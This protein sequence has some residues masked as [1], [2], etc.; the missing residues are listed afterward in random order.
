MSWGGETTL[1]SS[2]T[3]LVGGVSA[4]ETIQNGE[5]G[6]VW[7]EGA[8]SPYTV[9][10]ALITPTPETM[11]TTHAEGIWSG[12]ERYI[13]HANGHYWAVF[14]DGTEAVLFSSADASS[15]TSQGTVNVLAGEVEKPSDVSARFSGTTII[16]AYGDAES[17]SPWNQLY[18]RHGT[19]NAGGTVTWWPAASD[20]LVIQ[21]ADHEL[22]THAAFDSNGL[23]WIGG[24]GLSQEHFNV[25]RGSAAQSPTWTD[26]STTDYVGTV[27][28]GPHS[29]VLFPIA[30]PSDMYGL[31]SSN[32][33]STNRHIIGTGWDDSAGSWGSWQE[34]VATDLYD[35]YNA[36]N[37]C[38]QKWSAAKTSVGEIHLAYIDDAGVIKHRKGT[39][40]LA[41]VWSTVDADVTGL[42]SHRRLTLTANGNNLVLIY[43]KNDDKLYYREW[44]G[45]SWS[46]ELT[47]KSSS[48]PLVG[49]VSAYE[50]V[51]NGEI[52]VIWADGAAS[53]YTVQFAL[54][55]PTP[56]TMTMTHTDGIWSGTERYIHHANGH[57]WAVFY[58]GT[59]AVLFSSPDASTWTSQG[60]VNVL[61]GEVEKPADV[62][63]RFSGTTVIVAYG[64]D[65]TPSPYNQLYYRHGTLNAGG[66]VT[67]WPA[68]SDELIV[69]AGDHETNTHAAFD[70]AGLPWIG[71]SGDDD[72]N[73]FVHRGSAAQ[74]PTWTDRSTTDYGGTTQGGPHSTVLFPIADPG[75]M[76]GLTNAN[77]GSS[78]RDIIGTGWDDS[79]GSWGSWQE[80]VAT[81]LSN[82]A[83]NA[84]D[85]MR[86]WSAVK[87]SLGEIHLV[88]IDDAGV[89]KHRKGTNALAPVWSTVDSDVTGLTSHERLT[90]AANDNSLVLV[91]DKNDEKLYYREWDGASWSGE[92]TLKSSSTPLVGGVSAYES[93]QNGEI[94]VVWA[95]GAASPYDVIFALISPAASAAVTGTITPSSDEA[96]IVSGG[97][98]VIITLMGDTWVAAGATFDAER[99]AII[100]GLDS[101][102][103]EG[104]GWDAVVK[105]GLGVTDVV[106]TSATVVTVTLPAFG[107]YDI[108]ATETI[109]VTV[110]AS[111][112]SGAG[113]IAATP[114]FDV[115]PVGPTSEGFNDPTADATRSGTPATTPA[116]AYTAN[117]TYADI[118]DLTEHDYFTYGFCIPSGATIQGV[119][120][121]TEWHTTK[122]T[123]TGYLTL[124]L[125]S[126]VGTLFGSTK[127]TPT[128]DGTTDIVHTLG[129]SV[130]GWGAALTEPIIN[131]TDFG[132]SLLY[133]KTAGGGGNHAFVDNVDIKVHFS[134]G[135][136]GCGSGTAAL[137][138]TITPSTTESEIVSGGK[139]LAITLT[140]DTWVA[141]GPT[142]DAERQA[143]IN[144]LDSAQGEANGWD[145]VVKTGLAVTDVART[146]STVVTVTLPAFGS[147]DISA[148][149]TISATVPASALVGT[150]AILATPTF[151]ITFET[152]VAAVTGTI[153]PS[154][155]EAD[156]V[157]GGKTVLLTLTGDTWVAAGPTFDAE[158]QNIIDGLD[159]A[160]AETNGWDAEVKAGLAVTD[161]VRTSATLVTVTLPAFANYDVGSNETITATVPASAL[162]GTSPLVATPT[163]EVIAYSL[164]GQQEFVDDG[165]FTVP[166]GVTDITIKAWGGGGGSGSKAIASG[167]DGAAGGYVQHDVSGLTG[168]DTFTIAIGRAGEGGNTCGTHAGGAGGYAGG[169]GALSGPGNDGAGSGSGGLGGDGYSTFDGGDGKWGSGGGGGGASVVTN[170]QTTTEI[171]IAGGGGGG[172]TAWSAAWGGNGGPGCAQVGGDSGGD[173][174]GGGGGGACLGQTTQSGSAQTPANAAE[175][176]GHAEGGEGS[177]TT[178]AQKK[179][180]DGKVVI[181]WGS[182]AT[183][184]LKGTLVPSATRGEIA[185][186]GETLVITLNGDTWDGA[187]GADNAQTTALISGIDSNVAEA[188]GWDAVVKADLTFDDVVRTSDTVVT[189]TL[190]LEPTY[191]IT[192]NE[193]ITVT[194]PATAL[195]GGSS[196]I[197]TPTFTINPG[198]ASTESR[199]AAAS[200]DAEE[201]LS[202]NAVDLSGA[203]LQLIDSGGAQQVGMRF[204]NLLIPPGSTVTNAYLEFTTDAVQSGSTNL[205]FRAE[206]AD[207]PPTFG[208]PNSDISVRTLTTASVAWNSVP[209][210]NTLD[211]T[212]QT[213]DLSSVI[214]EIVDLGG[215]TA[216]NAMALHA[217]GSGARTA[218]AYDG[219]PAE[220]PLLHI[221]FLPGPPPPPTSSLDIRV[222]A[223]TDDAEEMLG[224]GAVDL[225]SNDLQL[226]DDS[227]AQEVGMRFLN[228]TVPPGSTI[229]NAYLEFTADVANLGTTDLTVHG[230]AADDPATFAGGVADLSGRL[231]TDASVDWSGVAAWDTPDQAYQSADLSP[232]VQELID[233]GGWTSGNAVALLVSGSGRRTGIAYDQDSAKA[234]LLHLEYQLPAALPPTSVERRISASDDDAEERISDGATSVTSGDLE[235]IEEA[236]GDQEVGMRF[237]NLTI[238]KGAAITNAYIE[239]TTQQVYSG[240]TDLTFHAQA[241]DD[242]TTFTTTNSDITN[243][244]KSAASV[245][246]NSVPAW[247]TIGE[248]HRTPDLSAIIQETVDRSGWASGN[249]LAVIVTGTGKREA[250]AYDTNPLAAPLLHIEY[251]PDCNDGNICTVDTWDYATQ[252]CSN[253]GPAAN[254]FACSDSLYCTTGNLCAAGVCGA[255]VDCSFLDNQCAVGTCDEATDACVAQYSTSWFDQ[256]WQY[257]KAITIDS[258]KV[259][260]DLD[261]FPVLVSFTDTDLAAGARD[262]GFDLAFTDSDGVTQLDHEIEKYASGTGEL[263]AWVRVRLSSTTDKQIYLYYG[264]PAAADQQTVAGVWTSNYAAVWHLKEEQSGTGNNGL[265]QDS[266]SNNRDADDEVSA[267]GQ[268]GKIGAGQQVD[269]TDDRVEIPSSATTG[270][271]QFAFSVWV[272]T[273]E[274]GTNGSYWL[275]PSVFGQ[276]TSGQST[277]DAGITTNNGYIGFW[278]G[279]TPVSDASYLSST[280]QVNDDA[281]HHI[282]LSND[283]ANAS[284]YVD[285][286]FQSSVATGLSLNS[287]AFWAGAKGGPESPGDH[288]NGTLDE[289]RVLSSPLS[290]DWI[291][292]EYNNQSSPG[293][294]YSL[295]AEQ[296]RITTCQDCDDGNVCTV[297]S[298]NSGSG[299]CDNDAG[300]ADGLSCSDGLF[301]TTGDICSSGACGTATD[302]SYLDNQCIL[303]VCD[304]GTDACIG[305]GNGGWYDANWTVRKVVTVD[306]AQ[307][308]ADLSDF[309]VLVSVTDAELAAGARADGF[310]F[311]FTDTDEITKLDHEIEKYDSGTG[312]L[313]AWV[314]VPNLTSAVDKVLYLYYGNAS[315]TNQQNPAGV[316]DSNY[317]SVHHLAETP[318]G[319]GSGSVSRVGSWTTSQASSFTYNVGAGSDR[320][321]LVATGY[322]ESS[323]NDTDVTGVTWGGQALTPISEATVFSSNTYARV[324]LWYLDESGV[325]AA[326]GSS[327]AVTYGNGG[328]DRPWH[329]VTTYQDVDQTTPIADSDLNS[330]TSVDPIEATVNVSNG[331]MAVASAFCGDNSTYTWGNGW[332]EGADEQ[333]GSETIS[334]AEHPASG[335]GTDTASAD[336]DG[337]MNRQVIVAAV[338]N[339]A[340]GG[341]T[342]LDS[343]AN[344]N[345]GQATGS[346]D[347]ADQVAGQIAGSL[348]FDASDDYVAVPHAPSFLVDDGS[349]SFWFK[350]G[351]VGTAQGLWCKDSANN[352]TGGHLCIYLMADSTLSARI[353]DTATGYTVASS[354]VSAGTWY[355]VTFSFGGAGMKLH[356]NAGAPATD[357]YTGG[358]GTSSGGAGNFEPAAFGAANDLSDDLIGT[359]IG[360]PFG[361]QL[362]EVRFSTLA[363]PDAWIQTE[364]SNQSAPGAFLSLSAEESFGGVCG[365]C[366]DSN[367]CTID[368]WDSGTETCTN[369]AGAANGLACADNLFCTTGNLCAA[370]VCGA[371][372]DCSFLDGECSIGACDEPSDS[373]VPQLQGVCD[374]DDGNSCTTDSFDSATFTCLHNPA[375]NN[376]LA[377]DDG[378]Y[379]TS[380]ETCE[381]GFCGNGSV[382]DCTSEDDPAQCLIGVCDEATDACVGRVSGNNWADTDWT[383]R[384]TITVDSSKVL[385]DQTNFPVLI[386]RTDAELAA[387]A[388]ADGFDIFFTDDDAQTKL[389]HEIEKYV[390]GTGELVA[391]VRVPTLTG[392]SDKTLYMYYGNAADQQN[393]TGVWDA[394]FVGVY[395]LKEPLTA[396]SGSYSRRVGASYDDAEEND[397]GVIDL[398]SSDLELIEEGS[399]QEVGMR[400]SSMGIPVGATI[401][402]AYIE[403]TVD[404]V[405]TGTPSDLNFYAQ[406]AD[407]AG[408]FSSTTNDIS[409]RQKTATGVAWNSVPGWPTVAATHQTPDLS[410]IIQEVVDRPG[411]ASGNAI[412]VIVTGVGTRTAES[413]NGAVA[414]APLLV[415]DY[416]V[417]VEDSTSNTNHGTTLG[418][419]GSGNQVAGKI[420]WLGHPVQ[421]HRQRHP[422]RPRDR[423]LRQRYRYPRGLGAGPEPDERHR[424][425][426]LPA[427]RRSR[428]ARPVQPARRLELGL[429]RRLAPERRSLGHG[430]S[431]AG[432]HVEQQRRQLQ[433]NHDER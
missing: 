369:D 107:S 248:T 417:Y 8:A 309:A 258:A 154:A 252:S 356:V 214:Q 213:P 415:V 370:G 263:V 67:W 196:V 51:Q 33:F 392:S 272:K 151:A 80:V 66:T 147:F 259:T 69:Q 36:S 355:H 41:P 226:V 195:V 388:R 300:A 398:T 333:G 129:S 167:G 432:Q 111:A 85:C 281:W 239:F 57:Y 397:S 408:T 34:V 260:A 245:T 172:G 165:V 203:A 20:H 37:K 124:Q 173:G 209:S 334:T 184:G 279:V 230:Q 318:S 140:G 305:Q 311:V 291:Q 299:S 361:G 278:S 233:R 35:C 254:G 7:A 271:S 306:S 193:T 43:D 412:V 10:F 75:D 53:P 303:G 220:A 205:T 178:C 236:S 391:W 297:D 282:L 335:G 421:G 256:D 409:S 360:F 54:I 216:G 24:S 108:A 31:T 223:S 325:Q 394:N 296:D 348:D 371:A 46:A 162:V 197:A 225:A 127:V 357:A 288:H 262:D 105:A 269:R 188:A 353:Q 413:Y 294:F 331:A 176:T 382:I 131:D 132:V 4:Y 77:A 95:E 350:A 38:H 135:S 323:T 319:G 231:K 389:D 267:T 420:D 102:Q 145:A 49:G 79:A 148:N 74:S 198:T 153:T 280:L 429:Q 403:F 354:A 44:D 287:T 372:T 185:S 249:A 367:S 427:L 285:G 302:C 424:Q 332:S 268:T 345:D 364:Y 393:V 289:L 228:V 329:A 103:A 234:P 14:Y 47:L 344:N 317:A 171:V 229:T 327:V 2:S 373:C 126:D 201:L 99:Q 63:A 27:N 337:S 286:A 222:S 16:V 313:V 112:L 400:F 215:W 163:F 207:D 320:I 237:L 18:Y 70:S 406:A 241:A 387:N 293:T 330:T 110:P 23:P 83:D 93:I 250:D 72:E 59:E 419:M 88:Y 82:C 246:W 204:Q 182:G 183:A 30:D 301:C 84:D 274:T 247:N 119:E 430:A 433:R 52:G 304:E 227:G 379:C 312:E 390:T 87:T 113:A 273:T 416:S 244:S 264:N 284:L 181:V 28:D 199:V 346:M 3:P 62:S 378:L 179:G 362:D 141:S 363:R 73:F 39:N 340:G 144:G 164:S 149:E 12:T 200:D 235:M 314:R 322:E 64:D 98:T 166:A 56:E 224:S 89:I 21:L 221:D 404:E 130:D 232:I 283:G 277:G 358:L 104:T 45:A 109:T 58:D 180:T 377:C 385:S 123:D 86:K 261:D 208:V 159:S 324:E 418:A 218:T 160:Q 276:A 349:V 29:T 206:A 351:A 375:P 255:P 217:T 116:N 194:V 359:P 26:R 423:E 414:L 32:F 308:T 138:G 386:S 402:N 50:S 380:G 410:A 326:S 168:D 257:R 338:L 134:G 133:T 431:V 90:L 270:L 396:G 96:G 422:A 19:L 100:N 76:Y 91:Y 139:T 376:G 395:H 191:Y 106:R 157:T 156:I 55:T 292:T 117:D 60:T 137:S 210:W 136:G 1:K 347:G 94:G 365:D 68:G 425:G 71:G 190:P 192:A 405:S 155:T 115:D 411:W 177:T 189:I 339:P 187:I 25:H 5:I 161:V 101:A 61:A 118:R 243:R 120:V 328:P 295:S 125:R 13:H 22:S 381:A 9:Q 242:P 175:A 428:L 6:V 211:E 169:N 310:D 253:D 401:T 343:T 11:T 315:A 290:A 143:I 146:S 202:S 122:V 114:T 158:R 342:I 265:Y 374:C 383:Y 352:D 426:D 336:F 275:R 307:V 366:D 399:S 238:P 97:K 42:T 128:I 266:T 341:S 212:H 186:G 17:P 240:S 92:L 407:S 384:K 78:N 15:W 174:S 65:N 40:A 321:L 251:G 152:L 142:F 219:T 316:W 368:S 48:T 170:D 121:R 298:W 150:S 81:D